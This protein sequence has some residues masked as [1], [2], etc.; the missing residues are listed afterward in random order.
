VRL[1]TRG[2]YDWSHRY[3]LIVQARCGTDALR[4]WRSGPARVD[5]ISDF[6]ANAGH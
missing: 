5:G 1:L 4:S 6:V 2:G 3:P